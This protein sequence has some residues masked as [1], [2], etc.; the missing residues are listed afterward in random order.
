M[1]KKV[2]FVCTHNAA[3]SQ[4]AEAF[5]N[6][7]CGDRYEAQSAGIEPSTINPYVMEAMAKAGVDMSQ[8]WSKSIE[9]FR[10]RV[11]DIVVTVC[12][13]AREV[14]PFFPGERLLHQSFDDPSQFHGSHDVVLADVIRVR[15]EIK[16][17]VVKTFNHNPESLMKERA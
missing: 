6:A 17:W 7:C 9:E 8:H 10:G 16:A 2:L 13:H 12:D 4:M 5:L 15:D 14:C 3:R 11:F 1:K